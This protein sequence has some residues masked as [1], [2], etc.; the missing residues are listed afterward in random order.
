MVHLGRGEGIYY[1]ESDMA[2]TL[3]FV[4]DVDDTLYLRSEPY[5]RT[6]RRFFGEEERAAVDE[7]AL[8][9]SGTRYKDEFYWRRERG[10]IT[11]D[12][13]LT[14]RTLF[15]MR[16]V[17]ISLTESEARD[18]ERLYTENLK[19]IRMLPPFRDLLTEFAAAGVNMGILTN[20][21][22]DRQREKIR[23]LGADRLIPEGN[24]LVSG[25]VGTA[26]PDPG[27]FR[28]F[29]A[30]TGFP[31]ER[32]LMTGDAYS[33]D[34]SGA[35]SAGWRAVWLNLRGEDGD[36]AVEFESPDAE[37]VCAYLRHA[38]GL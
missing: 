30:R 34:I 21:P 31:P 13:M 33:T 3:M 23:A 6:F 36:C 2:E 28:A 19:T 25:D 10:E 32:I 17:G 14:G 7:E 26:K 29:E 5:L 22:S 38:A 8:L 35:D 11:M 20:G 24:I 18:F 12:G 16:S 27:I 37:Q 15:T 1:P 9:A 4:F